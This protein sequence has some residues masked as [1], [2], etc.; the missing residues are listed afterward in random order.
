MEGETALTPPPPVDPRHFTALYE[1][2]FAERIEKFGEKDART[3]EVAR[4]LGL[5]LAKQGDRANAETW[6]RRALSISEQMHQPRSRELCEAREALARV[7]TGE[8]ERRELHRL[9]SRSDDA[10]TAARNLAQLAALEG[11]DVSLLRQALAQ[12]ERATGPQSAP[13]ALRLNDLGLALQEPEPAVSTGLFRRALAINQRTLGAQHP[14]TATTMNNLANVLAATGEA[15]AAEV[16]QRRAYA[17]FVA[18]LGPQH[19]RSG[20]TA[21]NLAGT[22]M[23]LGRQAEGKKWFTTA[24]TIFEQALG[25][26]HAWTREAAEN[27]R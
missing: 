17:V 26:D 24:H 15:S 9:A 23:T 16:L 3:A 21:S 12:Q 8:S 2:A 1:R 22:L 6:L 4:N 10:A 14:E 19:V 13:V 18:R 7:V 11:N 5:F 20:I 27:S 25:P